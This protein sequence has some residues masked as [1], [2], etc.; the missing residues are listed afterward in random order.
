MM[1]TTCDPWVKQQATDID[2]TTVSC[3]HR[4]TLSRAS[5]LA[6]CALPVTP[7]SNSRRQT[8]PW[9]L[10]AAIH[11]APPIVRFGAERHSSDRSVQ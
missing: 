11:R 9:P 7:G 4:A 2:M 10:S 6:Q 1:R 8:L 5:A 3:N